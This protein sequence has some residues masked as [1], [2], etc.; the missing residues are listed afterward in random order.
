MNVRKIFPFYETIFQ[1]LKMLQI[2]VLSDILLY[3]PNN[4]KDHQFFFYGEKIGAN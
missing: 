4:N 3:D 1:A 2:Y